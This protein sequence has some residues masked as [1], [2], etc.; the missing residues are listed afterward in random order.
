MEASSTPRRAPCVQRLASPR[1]T[2]ALAATLAVL[3]HGCAAVPFAVLGGFLV[4]AG[5]GAVVKTGT[6]YRAGGVAYR[7]FAIPM[8]DVHAAVLEGFR[9]TGIVVAKD[10]T[11]KKGEL[12]VEGCMQ[13]RSVRVYLTPLTPALTAMKLVVK[14]NVLMGDKATASEL[15]G[16]TERVLRENPAFAPLLL[17]I[18]TARGPRVYATRPIRPY[19]T[20]ARRPVR[21][22]PPASGSRLAAGRA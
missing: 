20:L 14:R 6:E 13:W 10:E 2:C 16:Q 7:T 3:L 1:A 19:Q 15:V 17:G 5:G 18:G 4:Q 22:P 11:S 8:A 12:T 9:R 21:P